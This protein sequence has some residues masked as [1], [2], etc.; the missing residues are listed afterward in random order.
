MARFCRDG[1]LVGGVVESVAGVRWMITHLFV[2]V[3]PMALGARFGRPKLR[4]AVKTVLKLRI[5]GDK[6][7]IEM[8]PENPNQMTFARFGEP[9]QIITRGGAGL[10]CGRGALDPHSARSCR[11]VF[12][13]VCEPV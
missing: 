6:G 12:G 9:K 2:P 10:G 11:G 1:A 8:G 13:R 5:Y 3:M 4:W 7:G